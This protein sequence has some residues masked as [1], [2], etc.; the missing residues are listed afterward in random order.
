MMGDFLSRAASSDA[1]TV[2]EDVTF[3]HFVNFSWPQDHPP[4]NTHN[5]RNCKLLLLCI[6]EKLENIIADDDAFLSAEHARCHC[7]L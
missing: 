3:C 6:F 2:E 4:I 5:G 7:G 1:T